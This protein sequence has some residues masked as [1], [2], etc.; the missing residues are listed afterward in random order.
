MARRLWLVAAALIA[1]IACTSTKVD[2]TAGGEAPRV[3]SSDTARPPVPPEFTPPADSTRTVAVPGNPGVRYHR[4]LVG[5][6]F[7]DSTS[8][9]TVNRLLQRY[10]AT[11]VGGLPRYGTSGAYILQLPDTVTTYE[12]LQGVINAITGESGVDF[13]FGTTWRDKLVPRSR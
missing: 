8:G 11:V 3:A 4:H 1:P 9:I 7:D 6:V 2:R 5:V 12:G 10:Q 13:A